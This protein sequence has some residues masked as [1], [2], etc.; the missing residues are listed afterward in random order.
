MKIRV[1]VPSSLLYVQGLSMTGEHT[2]RAGQEGQWIRRLISPICFMSRTCAWSD[3][4]RVIAP[5]AQPDSLSLLRPFFPLHLLSI[6][7]ARA[8]QEI[9]G[10]IWEVRALAKQGPART[11]RS[12]RVKLN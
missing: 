11:R 8:L 1:Q 2:G 12:P 6:L 4:L 7:A 5:S 10:E 9:A 3:S